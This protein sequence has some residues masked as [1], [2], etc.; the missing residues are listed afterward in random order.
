VNRIHWLS[1]G[2]PCQRTGGY[3]YNSRITDALRCL[4]V[5]VII[6]SLEGD[7]PWPQCAH[8]DVLAAI[9]DDAIVVADGLLWPGLEPD[10]REALCGRC[11]VWVVVH[12]VLDKEGSSDPTLIE[13][14][15]AALRE[16]HGW[17][18]TSQ[19]TADLV[20]GRMGGGPSAVV[21]PGT[22]PPP[23]SSRSHSAEIQ[24]LNV[25]HVIPRKG[26]RTLIEGLSAV[27][28]LPWTMHIVGSMLRDIQW[29]TAIQEEVIGLGLE[30]RIHF[31]GELNEADMESAYRSADVLVHTAD[32]EAYG[33]V[34]TEALVR[35]LP[36]IST[37]AGALDDLESTLIEMVDAGDARDLS[38]ALR[39]AIQ[40]HPRTHIPAPLFP[41]W[42][43]QAERL[44]ERL[45]LDSEGFSVDWLRLRE[46]HDHAA[47]STRL[48]DAF[49]SA[50]G[51]GTHTLMELATGLG[52]GARFVS[53]NMSE[54][55]NWVLVDHD[56][57]LLS[58][59]DTDMVHRGVQY[60]TV[61]HDLRDI[62]DLQE[63][64]DGITTQ[65]LLDLVSHE[66]LER[67]ADWLTVRSVPFL[68]ALTVTGEVKWGP[69]DTRDESIQ[70]AFRTHQTWDRGFGSS[71]G[72]KAALVLKSLLEERGFTVLLEAA[73]WAIPA[74]C[75]SMISAMVEGTAAAAREA[76]ED[77]GV[78]VNTV[79][80]WRSSRMA[81]LGSLSVTV[82]HWDL[83]AIP[84]HGG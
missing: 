54:V 75:E 58:A 35:G 37:P 72:P 33:M 64:A 46:P 65:A 73:D 23:V 4:G 16:A 67:F 51:P 56:P 36:V 32:F 43:E 6:H 80:A 5:D 40:A 13:R 11:S 22:E 7:W 28:D 78:S 50:L 74:T 62:T 60:R 68:G 49:A 17:F 1:P 9:P 38:A 59:L 81:A 12:S 71:P 42:A 52:S 34:L 76:A 3:L 15:V 14:E 61:Q 18:A 21:I 53:A 26:H 31:L 29:A 10:E 66:W 47:R 83:L 27:R 79:D 24:L 82:G 19:R 55:P 41:T 57:Q 48:V 8:D 44:M 20:A 30:N 63:Q 2:D 45:G 70:H 25:A 69:S 84:K 39:T 77:A